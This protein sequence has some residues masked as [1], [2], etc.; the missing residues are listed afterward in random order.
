MPNVIYT[1]ANAGASSRQT[2]SDMSEER[3]RL[4]VHR[5]LTCFLRLFFAQV[6]HAQEALHRGMSLQLA[7]C[8]TFCT[9]PS[10][11]SETTSGRTFVGGSVAQ[12]CQP[13]Q[14]SNVPAS[15]PASR[16]VLVLRTSATVTTTRSRAGV[17]LPF[18][19]AVS[20]RAG[21]DRG[22]R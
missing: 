4:R 22:V 8:G 12:V 6:S 5:E 2:F 11:G 18:A 3:H 21:R 1:R 16:A 9:P 13:S 7:N 15:V 10:G 20:S 14:E 17:T 19:Q